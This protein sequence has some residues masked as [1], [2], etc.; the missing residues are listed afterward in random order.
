MTRLGV[1]FQALSAA[2]AQ[3]GTVAAEFG[4]G[5]G[6]VGSTPRA[7]GATGE[8]SVLLDRVLSALSDALRKAERELQQ[9]SGHLSA[10]ADSYARTERA[11]A[12]WRIPGAGGRAG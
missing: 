7:Q 11:L 2:S 3:V 5:C 10:T 4:R 9:V 8:A 1:D 12:A 6:Q